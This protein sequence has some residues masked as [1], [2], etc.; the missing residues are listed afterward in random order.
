[1]TAL[2]GGFVGNLAFFGLKLLEWMQGV[3]EGEWDESWRSGRGRSCQS[4]AGKTYTFI[5]Q[6]DWP[7]F[8]RCPS[9]SP[10]ALSLHSTLHFAHPISWTDKGNYTCVAENS[11]TV[12]GTTHTSSMA[13]SV[14]H[15]PVILNG[16]HEDGMIGLA[17]AELG[18]KVG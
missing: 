18:Q 14:T 16:R 12:P 9:G 17:A 8:S 11:P 1:M 15:E 7:N 13:L 2:P 6:L 5:H 3:G 10:C 4:F